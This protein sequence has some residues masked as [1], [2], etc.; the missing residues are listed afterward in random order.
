MR[1]L[2]SLLTGFAQSCI[3]IRTERYLGGIASLKTSLSHTNTCE[4]LK[5]WNC[6]GGHG[7]IHLP[8]PLS[9]V[10]RS[11]FTSMETALDNDI[12]H[13]FPQWGRVTRNCHFKKRVFHPIHC[14]P[15]SQCQSLIV[16][17]GQKEPPY[18]PWTQ[19]FHK[20]TKTHESVT[21][22]GTSE[23]GRLSTLM[24]TRKHSSYR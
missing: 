8:G 20:A 23:C 24:E 13:S 21:D 15:R 17:M 6:R 1:T 22:P 4:H 18:S 9:M 3:Q 16:L 11:P 10:A 19:T 2:S 7:A 14:R 5:A 12:V